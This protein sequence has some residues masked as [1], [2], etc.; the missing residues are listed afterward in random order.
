M[1]LAS[2]TYHPMVM[3][4]CS[5]LVPG[6]CEVLEHVDM[7]KVLIQKVLITRK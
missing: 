4:E 3:I 2:S 1:L 6:A 5:K 7:W